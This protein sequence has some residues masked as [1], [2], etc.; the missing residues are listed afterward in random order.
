V[1]RF[2]TPF[3]GKRFIG[4]KKRHIFHD[5]IFEVVL[6]GSKGCSIDDLPLADVQTFDPD[7]AARALERGFSPCPCCLGPCQADENQ[8]LT[9]TSH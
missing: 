4:D 5:S 2:Q 6:P 8:R 7:S 1:I 9:D 3:D